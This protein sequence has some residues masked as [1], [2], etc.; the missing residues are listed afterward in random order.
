MLD[1][2]FPVMVLKCVP[3]VLNAVLT[4]AYQRSRPAARKMPTAAIKMMVEVN[5]A[6]AASSR[7]KLFS[8]SRLLPEKSLQAHQE[9]EGITLFNVFTELAIVLK[10]PLRAP[11]QT[12][13]PA[14][15]KMPTA[16]IMMT[17]E[18]VSAVAVSSRKNLLRPFIP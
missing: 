7:K 8:S 6:V 9:P 1:V 2:I 11:Y 10:E 12:A 5:S 18:V 14:A 16:A 13:R 17:M 15:S 3:A 4:P